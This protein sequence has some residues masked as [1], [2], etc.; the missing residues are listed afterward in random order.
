MLAV[1]NA[2]ILSLTDFLYRASVFSPVE[3]SEAG[4]WNFA[5]FDWNLAWPRTAFQT[6]RATKC[7][8]IA[9]GEPKSSVRDALLANEP[10]KG[11]REIV[12][13]F[14][15]PEDDSPS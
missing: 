13:L 7:L 3:L 5:N 9:D 1:S 11:V 14:E 15:R 4:C 12:L 8:F 6:Q 2:I 10:G